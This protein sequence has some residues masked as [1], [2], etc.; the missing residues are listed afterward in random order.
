MPTRRAVPFK[1]SSA[2][3]AETSM[4]IDAK[5]VLCGP[6]YDEYDA[7]WPDGRRDHGTTGVRP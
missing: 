7:R 5:R 6:Q 4:F 1:S 3:P 2:I